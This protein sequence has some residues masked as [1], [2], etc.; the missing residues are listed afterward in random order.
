MLFNVYILSEQQAL[1]RLL[2]V[3]CIQIG[4]QCVLIYHPLIDGHGVDSCSLE[5]VI[6]IPDLRG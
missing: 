4:F 3:I 5:I 2:K 1:I 6:E